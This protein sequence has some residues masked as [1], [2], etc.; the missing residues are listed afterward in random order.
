MFWS[1]LP[2]ST[3][4]LQYLLLTVIE[5]AATTGAAIATPTPISVNPSEDFVSPL[6]ISPT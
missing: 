2:A 5:G 3:I 4:F 1:A 6:L